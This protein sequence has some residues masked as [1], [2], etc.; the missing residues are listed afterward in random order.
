MQGMHEML[1]SPTLLAPRAVGGLLLFLVGVRLWGEFYDYS[2]Q[3][4]LGYR[5]RVWLRVRLRERFRV[6]ASS[7]T[8]RCKGG[9]A[10]R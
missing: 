10:F 3:V 6:R 9:S 5:V 2:L 7:T 1:H 4:S 8:T